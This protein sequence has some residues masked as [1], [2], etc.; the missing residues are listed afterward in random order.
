MVLIDFFTFTLYFTC[1]EKNQVQNP[2]FEW[3]RQK[4]H[5]K[6]SYVFSNHPRSIHPPLPTTSKS[7]N[8]VRFSPTGTNKL[9][10]LNKI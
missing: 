2:D 5:E 3:R 4:L 6:M 7:R 1:N 8:L 10:M 9:W